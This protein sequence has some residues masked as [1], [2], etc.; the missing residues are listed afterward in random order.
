MSSS[1]V[2]GAVEMG[3]SKVV[4]IV[5]EIVGERS[6]NIIGKG[7]SSARGIKKGEITDQRAAANCVHAAI[8]AA[9]NSAGITLE[10][11]YLAATGRHLRG[12]HNLGVAHISSPEMGASEEDIA[13]ATRDG[14]S[15]KL[16]EDRIYIHHIRNGYA[17]D[18]KD[19]DQ[20]LGADGRKLEV[21]YW[22]VDGDERVVRRAIRTINSI[23]IQVH[24]L[25]LSGIASARTV[26]TADDRSAG[27]LVLDIG[28]GT[29]DYALYSRGRIIRA[30]AIAVGGDHLTND[31]AMGLR[32]NR[33]H[34]EYLKTNFGKA[35]IDRDDKHEKVW[36]IG[37]LTIGDRTIPRQAIY[38]IIHCRVA[39]LF[40]II[41]KE[42]A[43]VLSKEAAPAGVILTGGTSQLPDICDLAARKLDLPV[44]LGES[45]SWVSGDLRSPGLATGLGILN[46]AFE[47]Q[48]RLQRETR[49]ER[50]LMRKITK[51]FTP[52]PRREGV[53][54]L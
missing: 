44:R 43:G 18:G 42:L 23:E 41:R 22:S 31:L 2:I 11:L 24:D 1:K 39:E 47:D 49:G 27:C 17:I 9:E 10:G 36:L 40:T 46:L 21:S 12:Q 51:L 33:K 16:A 4:A 45:P 32:V 30:G 5:G 29:T 54:D 28:C 13:R 53:E 50:G 35:V 37:D 26:S 19:V 25:I 48:R 52:E 7:Q 34:A 20:P 8:L 38:Q 3:T 14:K 6:L 15:R